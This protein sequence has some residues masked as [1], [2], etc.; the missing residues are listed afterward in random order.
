MDHTDVPHDH[1]ELGMRP[2]R[3]VFLNI[4][5]TCLVTLALVIMSIALVQSVSY[6][7]PRIVISH[8]FDRL[9]S[10]G[11][12]IA[13]H[14]GWALGVFIPMQL[15]FY[16]LIIG[17]QIAGDAES[18]AATRKSLG[19]LAVLMTALLF[20]SIVSMVGAAMQGTV[21]PGLLMVYLPPAVLMFVLASQVERFS[22]THGEAQLRASVTHRNALLAQRAIV[23]RPARWVL[24]AVL[25]NLGVVTVLGVGVVR[26][27]GDNSKEAVGNALPMLVTAFLISAVLLIAVTVL[28]LWLYQAKTDRFSKV[29]AATLVALVFAM[30]FGVALTYE[31]EG[32]NGLGAGLI[33]LL[34]WTGVSAFTPTRKLPQGVRNFTLGG[35]SA[36]LALF[37]L[38]R[39]IKFEEQKIRELEAL[40][41]GPHNNESDPKV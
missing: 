38:D 19:S 36:R 9:I 10:F 39:S 34:V 6:S 25:A 32:A 40:N 26:V 22:T 16:A 2:L 15:G 5:L 12:E 29:G 24:P 11:P 31:S 30:Y 3:G 20:P 4:T 18:T 1:H 28:G 33:L 13:D 41:S 17:K 8:A 21:S 35:A 23:H 37:R 14:L 27:V 7:P